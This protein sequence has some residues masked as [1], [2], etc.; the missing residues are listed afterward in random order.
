MYTAIFV[1]ESVLASAFPLLT[2]LHL[3]QMKEWRRD[4]LR[5]HL[6]REG[7]VRSLLGWTRPTALLL[8]LTL[9]PWED[10]A[11]WV[12]LCFSVFAAIGVLQILLRRQP[13]PLPTAKAILTLTL[14]L[15][16]ITLISIAWAQRTILL[17]WAALIPLL[18]PLAVLCAWTV[19]LPLDRALKQ[20]TFRRASRAREKFPPQTIV[21]GIAGSVGKTTVKSLLAHL[22]QDRQ[23]WFTPE[24]VNT[25]MGIA[26]WLLRRERSGP[27]PGIIIV[28]MGAYARG[29][30]AQS[31][32]FL[33]PTIGVIT[34]LGGDHLALFGSTEAIVKA[35]AELLDALPRSG[36]AFLL[37]DNEESRELHAPSPTTLAGLSARADIRGTSLILDEHG[38]HFTIGDTRFTSPLQGMHNASNAILAIAVASHCGIEPS[39]I[40]ALLATC[41]PPPR[42]FN[43]RKESGV[44]ILDDTYNVSVLS[45][46][47]VID[48]S[49]SQKNSTKILLTSGLLELGTAEEEKH[50]HSF[51]SQASDTFDR[52][53]FTTIAGAKC[54][55][56][57]YGKP[58]E[59]L[60]KKTMMIPHDALLVC[61]GRMSPSTISALLPTDTPLS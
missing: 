38:A 11:F 2:F 14:S 59:I 19:T 28:E 42:T 39:R 32:S 58:V 22:L 17:P 24:H 5:E 54:F 53:I 7:Y 46:Q 13:Y 57:G 33:Q 61:I 1:F 45:F 47:A 15:G 9:Y 21:I 30:I 41:T 37:A 34:A 18:S 12:L 20:R 10:P 3:F 23:P 8:L 51:G 36:H 40:A 27:I 56:E 43:V 55:S 6:R 50:L 26:Q 31:C 48:W 25:E 60:S 29:E 16:L 44:T 49:G 4:R 35:N 52:V